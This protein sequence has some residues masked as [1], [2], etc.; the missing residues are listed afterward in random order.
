M[1]CVS[2]TFVAC[3]LQDLHS[4]IL[5]MFIYKQGLT[6]QLSILFMTSLHAN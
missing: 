4:H 2:A 1:V 3:N 5:R 6:N